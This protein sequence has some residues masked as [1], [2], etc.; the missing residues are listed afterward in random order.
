MATSRSQPYDAHPAGSVVTPLELSDPP[1][2]IAL[3]GSDNS[4]GGAAAGDPLHV[5][6]R[7]VRVAGQDEEQ[8]AQPAEVRRG[9]G[10]RLLAIFMDGDPGRTFGTPGPR[11]RDMQQRRSGT[12]AGEDEGVE[13]R[14]LLVV[15]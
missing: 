9:H 11:T 5:S 3:R 13:L 10:V 1:G 12:A 15:R 8:V 7:E 14:Q 6:G 4:L 2:A